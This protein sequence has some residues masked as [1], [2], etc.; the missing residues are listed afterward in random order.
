MRGDPQVQALFRN[1]GATHISMKRLL[2]CMYPRKEFGSR[3]K[4]SEMLDEAQFFLTVFPKG[5]F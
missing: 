3:L 5:R 1:L 4:L 2:G